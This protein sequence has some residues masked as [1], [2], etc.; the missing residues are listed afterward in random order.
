MVFGKRR[1]TVIDIG[2]YK[3]SV[4]DIKEA[5]NK[6][7]KVL[8]IAQREVPYET[9]VN[10]IIKDPSVIAN[11]LQEIFSETGIKP[12]YILTTVSNDSLI[13]RNVTLPKMS[14][15]ELA[16]VIR[17]EIE[18]YIPFSAEYARLD[19]KILKTTDEEM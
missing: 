13:V 10:G 6:K 17:W 14:E 18:D 1:Y 8:N 7:I 11:R 12:G 2:S 19:Y 16:N 9:I 4:A 3:I 5:G 15:K